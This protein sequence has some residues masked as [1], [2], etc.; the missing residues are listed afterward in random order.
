LGRTQEATTHFD[1]AIRMFDSLIAKG[2]A[3]PFTRYYIAVAHALSGAVDR[4]FDALERVASEL[5]ALTVAR[6]R[7]DP[8]LEMLHREPRFDAL[9]SRFAAA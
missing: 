1:R 7:R 9:I 3:D 6:I 8:D 4:A 5:P 2:A